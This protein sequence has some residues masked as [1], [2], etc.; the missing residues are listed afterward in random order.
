MHV[1]Y[2]IKV[3]GTPI[4]VLHREAN[5]FMNSIW[6]QFNSFAQ[7]RGFTTRVEG[8]EFL[9]SLAWR[10]AAGRTMELVQKAGVR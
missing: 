3:D 4:K 7:Q 5:N 10:D 1:E 9:G 6:R 8:S 2:A